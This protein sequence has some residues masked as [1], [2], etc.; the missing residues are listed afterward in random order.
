MQF[1]LL[2]VTLLHSTQSLLFKVLDGKEAW[3]PCVIGTFYL[4]IVINGVVIKGFLKK[5]HMKNLTEKLVCFLNQLIASIP[6]IR[7]IALIS[8]DGIPIASV[9]PPGI[10]EGKMV[11]S[12]K[13]LIKS[14][15]GVV[16]EFT[17]GDIDNINV[18]NKDGAF[19]IMRAGSNAALS[20]LTARDIRFGLVFLDMKRTTEKIADVLSSISYDKQAAVEADKVSKI[21][22]ACGRCGGIIS[23]RKVA[24]F[25]PYCGFKLQNS[26]T[27]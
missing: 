18:F 26:K 6:E 11:K 19:F 24:Q 15:K 13:S 20:L 23:D 9:L 22:K 21:R 25:C 12:A 2:E 10:D 14:A 4:T 7:A 5:N 3:R 17:Q 27:F 16:D 1:D 8:D